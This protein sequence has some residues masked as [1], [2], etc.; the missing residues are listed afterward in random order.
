M[1][2]GTHKEK[3]WAAVETILADYTMRSEPVV[4]TCA[5]FGC[6][7]ELSLTEALAG[8]HCT[9]CANE[10]PINIMKVLKFK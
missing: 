3:E 9:R 2:L 5:K 7:K 6:G 8:K 1:R 10:K 4:N